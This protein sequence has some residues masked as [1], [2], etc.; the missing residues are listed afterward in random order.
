MAKKVEKEEN[1]K[2]EVKEE[3]KN[4]RHEVVVKIEGESWK[5]AMD[6]A[7]AKKQKT[8]KVDGFRTGKVPR[9]IY[10]KHYGKESLYMDATENV[11]EEAYNK[12][13]EDSKL[14]PVAQPE[15]DIKSLNDNHVEFIFK[16][17]TRPE[18]NVKKYQGLN[19]QPEKVEVTD[20]E[21]NHEMSHLLERYTELTI[22][23]KGAVENGD[24]AVIDFEG[25]K[26][27]KAFDGGKGENYSLEI[28]SNTFI[29]GFEEQVIG[30]N[31]GEEKDLNVSF[32]EDYGVADL[33]GK[34]VVFK[35]KVN[36]IKQKVTRELDEEFFEDLGMEGIDSEEKL[37]EEIKASIKAQK[38][39]DVENKY[40][41]KILEEVAK[42]V[43]VDIPEEMV[44]EETH[45]LIHRFE[46]QMKMQG[47][48]LD[49]Y[50]QFTQ[51]T[52]EDLHSKM[53]KEGYH[54][55][56]YRLMLEE[57]TKLE[58]IVVTDEEVDKEAKELAE[59]Y[60]MTEEEFL[61]E[62]GGKD[63]VKYDLEMRRTMDRLKE[64][65]K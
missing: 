51:T 54:N 52:P 36:E 11:M 18:V 10:E 40:I 13:M 53:E 56:L 45:R 35:V 39:M 21:I 22:K 31:V 14:V 62:F 28:G 19:I 58:S 42:S 34:P 30:M 44:E 15:V 9:D 2:E 46:D 64:L 7:F 61:K 6:K 23:E 47:I 50:Y 38:E 48:S 24:I 59:Q 4:N 37:K 41:D 16:I 43:E 3:K 1:V 57:I 60:K 5:K 33:A 63:M 8:A 26:D 32:P 20:E 27:G 49:L 65:N 12:A 25:F 17:I 55:V 29:P